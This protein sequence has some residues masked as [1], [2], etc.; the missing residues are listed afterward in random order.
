[1]KHLGRTLFLALVALGTACAHTPTTVRLIDGQLEE[2]GYVSP[3][4]YEHYLAAQLALDRGDAAKA[5]EE[6]EAALNFDPDSPYL[7]VRLA[8]IHARHG[9]SAEAHRHL[10]LALQAQPDHP[11]ALV[12]LGRLHWQEGKPRLA[13]D[14][15]RRC[16]SKSPRL[17]AAY[18]V[19]AEMLERLGRAD[20]ARRTLEQ[21]VKH[22]EAS[23][24]GHGSLAMLCLR[25]L[26]YSCAARQLRLVLQQQADPETLVR[27]AHVH[28]SRGELGDAVQLLREAFDRSGGNSGVASTLLEVLQQTGKRQAVDD[29]I[30]ILESSADENADQVGELAGLLLEAQRPERALTLIDAQLKRS[31]TAA[32]QVERAEALGR[33]GRGAEAKQL[34]RGLLGGLQGATAATRLARLLQREGA[35]AEASEVLRRELARQPGNESLVLALSG[36]LYLEDKAEPSLQVIRDA[37]ARQPRSRNLLFGLGA[38]QERVGRW[39]E[40]IATMR[41]VLTRSPQDAAAHNFIGYTQVEHGEDLKAAERSIRQALFLSPGEGYIIDSLGWLAYRQGRL[42][43]AR[44]LLEMAVRL[45]PREAEVLAHLAEVNAARSDLTSALRLLKRAVSISEDAKLTARLRKRLHELEKGRVG[46]R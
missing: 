13:E 37:L 28:R 23:A 38:A 34:L 41:Q 9:R 4:A 7:H 33:L 14:A 30:G 16:I 1:M 15:F 32:L 19:Y 24:D 29:L 45:A 12:L 40:A 10:Q 46:A 6:L 39:R 44:R 2:T 11:E 20:E 42:D 35:R 36:A 22:V 31:A 21:M 25:Q 17:A 3:S 5:A 43:E 8:E 26:D 27:L 18:S